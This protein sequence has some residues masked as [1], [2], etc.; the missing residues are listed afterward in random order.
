MTLVLRAAV[1]SAMEPRDAGMWME[2]T[3][4]AKHTTL[5][6]T[7]KLIVSHQSQLKVYLGVTVSL[8]SRCGVSSARVTTRLRSVYRS[9][10]KCLVSLVSIDL[11]PGAQFTHWGSFG[12]GADMGP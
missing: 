6:Y 8:W 9:V 3:A 5:L 1:S 4:H 10:L 7:Q 11:T 2:T 12:D